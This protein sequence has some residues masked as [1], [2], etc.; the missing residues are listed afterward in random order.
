VQTNVSKY[1]I[2]FSCKNNVNYD[3]SHLFYNA[4]SNYTH[5]PNKCSLQLNARYN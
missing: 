3:L 5:S 4:L 1:L 2:W